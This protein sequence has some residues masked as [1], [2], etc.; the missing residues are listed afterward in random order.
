MQATHLPALFSISRRR[1][2]VLDDVGHLDVTDR[3]RRAADLPG[4]AFVS[5]RAD[6][7][8]RRPRT[9]LPVPT[10]LFHSGETWLR[11]VGK[12]VARARAVGA[13]H[14]DDRHVREVRAVVELGDL[15][16]VP[17]GDLAEVDVGHGLTRQTDRSR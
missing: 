1:H 2:V 6:G 14:D 11:K 17:L 16:V 10:L 15:R 4:D 3:A 8:R 7:A 9:L 12:D 13:M 5:L